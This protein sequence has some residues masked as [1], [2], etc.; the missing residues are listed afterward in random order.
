MG[1]APVQALT[2]VATDAARSPAAP[3]AARSGGKI[4]DGSVTGIRMV[5]AVLMLGLVA[6]ISVEV[7]LRFFFNLPLDSVTEIASL[8]FIWLS[9]LGAAA[10]VPLAA[11][12]AVHPLDNRAGPVATVALRAVT[13]AAALAFGIFM[14]V[15]GNQFTASLAGQ[16]LPVTGVSSMWE[17]SAFPVCGVLMI[18]FTLIDAGRGI[19][20]LLAH[21]TD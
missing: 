9:M 14:T 16:T 13:T 7:I 6:L 11:H 10:A 1:S 5:L 15:S 12:M 19:K 20:Q 2:P 18:V 21:R 8:L 3:G 4:A 17:A